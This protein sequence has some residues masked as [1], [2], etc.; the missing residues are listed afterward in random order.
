MTAIEINEALRLGIEAHKLGKLQDADAYY[1]AILRTQ[2]HHSH[3]NHNMGVLA[4][5]KKNL[6]KSLSYFRAALES[7]RSVE[8]FWISYIDAL[9]KAGEKSLAEKKLY[10][11]RNTGI[12]GVEYHQLKRRIDILTGKASTKIMDRGPSEETL[13]NL[14]C[15]YNA[16]KFDVVLKEAE[17]LISKFPN[18]LILYNLFGA[19]SRAKGDL[20]NAISAY[21]RAI[22]LDPDYAQAHNNKG[23]ALKDKGKVA[24]AIDCYKRA[25]SI[26]PKYSDAYM[27]LGTALQEC[28]EFDQA[29]NS[30]V[31]AIQ[32]GGD[33]AEALNNMGN[34]FQQQNMLEKAIDSY[35][36]AIAI[37]PEYAEAHNNLGN[38][39]REFQKFDEALVSYRQALNLRSDFAEAHNNCGVLL[40][41][42]GKTEEAITA[43][44]AAVSF[45]PDYEKG[46]YNLSDALKGVIFNQPNPELGKILK[47]LLEMTTVVRPKDIARAAL[48]L[49]KHDVVLPRQL[50]PNNGNVSVQNFSE[51]INSLSKN[52]LLLTLMGVCPLPDVALEDLMGNLREYLLLNISIL[53]FPAYVLKLLSALALQ[54]FINGYI[55]VQNK[56]EER[57]LMDIDAAL[58]SALNDGKQP[59]PEE[60]LILA[61]YKP[62]HTYEWSDLLTKT[63]DIQ[64]V[65]IQQIEE[66][67]Q[68]KELKLHIRKLNAITDETSSTVR[69]QYEDSPYPR[70]INLRLHKNPTTISSVANKI[71]LNLFDDNVKKVE[72]PS[73]LIAGCGTGQHSIG[74]A[75]RFLNSEV[76][77]VDLSLS[78]LAYAKRKSDELAIKNIEYLQADILNLDKLERNFDIIESVGVL[79]HMSDPMDG[80]SVLVNRLKP[81]GLIKVGLYSELARQHIVKIRDEINNAEI[82]SNEADMKLFRRMVIYSNEDHHKLIQNSD[83]FYNMNTL[84]D[85]LFHVQEHRF[86]LLQIRDC[87]AQLGLKF[88]GFEIEKV[89]SHFKLNNTHANDLYDLTKWQKY[90]EA[91]PMTFAGM[92]QFWCQK[93]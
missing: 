39:L 4:L 23:N 7:D 18:N 42:I 21:N 16:N 74:T 51:V 32:F 31:S 10:E 34:I 73:I 83:D 6:D 20:D 12:I 84:K 69:N 76:L 9:I 22:S 72:H 15:I 35:K 2:P 38:A 75:T 28:G 36:Q 5:G 88:C 62:L 13:S 66:P 8:Q 68:E 41:E 58:G 53:K 89:V 26:N 48:S 3:A 59:R 71:G 57:V 30:Y 1:S 24:E 78:S 81:G 64:D 87:L 90:E 54:C 80:W 79:H 70:W 55:Y 33:N 61:T 44:V 52:P 37:K 85:L 56:S 77:A 86:N 49:T 27:N 67:R 43:F 65:Y 40:T 47:K 19:A 14:I 29:L 93:L 82:K 11:A 63:S 17:K 50:P 46:Y 91:N 25:L 92:Y 60:I 45:R